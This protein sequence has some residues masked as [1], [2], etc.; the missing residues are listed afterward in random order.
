MCLCEKLKD[1]HIVTIS[2]DGEN[3]WTIKRGYN[4]YELYASL[5][6]D[7]DF[8]IVKYCPRCGVELKKYDK[9]FKKGDKVEHKTWGKGTFMEYDSDPYACVIEFDEETDYGKVACVSVGLV[10]LI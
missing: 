6:Y 10:E 5:G 9:E 4:R 8:I 1:N 3:V 7:V 2:D